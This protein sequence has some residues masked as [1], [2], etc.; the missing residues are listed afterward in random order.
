MFL[1]YELSDKWYSP[2][3]SGLLGRLTS[4]KTTWPNIVPVRTFLLPARTNNQSNSVMICRIVIQS[5]P[6]WVH[7]LNQY[8]D[9]IRNWVAKKIVTHILTKTMTNQFILSI[10]HQL[11]LFVNA[12][13]LFSERD[14]VVFSILVIWYDSYC[15]TGI[16]SSTGQNRSS[17]G[18]VRFNVPIKIQPNKQF[19]A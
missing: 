3:P 19:L 15:M 2:S 4:Y 5:R 8:R 14:E 16:G 7:R 18:I 1:I 9:T 13:K 10:N 11:L 17:N 12:V 6:V